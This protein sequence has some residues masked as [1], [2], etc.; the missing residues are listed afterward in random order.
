MQINNLDFADLEELRE[1]KRQLVSEYKEHQADY[2]AARSQIRHKRQEEIK[3][4]REAE[5]WEQYE[6]FRRD[7]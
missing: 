7:L 3:E 5:K 1:K 6:T 2:N 4:R